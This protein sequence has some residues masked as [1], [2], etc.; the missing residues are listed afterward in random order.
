MIIGACPFIVVAWRLWR[1]ATTIKG[2]AIRLY[3]SWWRHATTV[4]YRSYPSRAYTL[5]NEWSFAGNK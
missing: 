1:H 3:S 2:R 5:A 4:G